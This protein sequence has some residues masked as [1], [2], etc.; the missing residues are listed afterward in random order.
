MTDTLF[1]KTCVTSRETNN[2]P[3]VVVGMPRSGS[4]FL[5]HVLSQ[6]PDWYVFDDLYLQDK[7]AEVGSKPGVSAPQMEKLLFFLG[8]QIRA[9]LRFGKYAIPHVREDE[10]DEMNAA[11]KNSFSDQDFDWLDLQKEWMVRLA[12][13][14]NCQNWGYKLPKAFRNMPQIRARYKDAKMVF[15]LR[16]PHDV[17]RSFKFITPDS[18]DGHPD[19]YHP[20]FYALYWRV[21]AQAYLK[22]KAANPEKTLLITFDDLTKHTQATGESLARFLGHDG[23]GPISK[24]ERPNSSFKSEGERK[25]L[26]GFEYWL[27]ATLCG[28]G[29]QALG[30]ESRKAPVPFRFSDLADLCVKSWRFARFKFK[31]SKI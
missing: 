22:E 14:N 31:R 11:I 10:I 25:D 13:R 20:V 27:I 15:L 17:L 12:Q 23:M 8:W 26:N 6:I 29:M 28:S 16:Q 2:A 3:V 24:P 19:R 5:S 1:S 30:F 21:A 18:Q 9:R 4:S 7:A